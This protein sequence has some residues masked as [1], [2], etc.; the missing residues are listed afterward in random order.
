MIREG[1]AKGGTGE[2]LP[3]V[4]MMAVMTEVMAGETNRL[5]EGGAKTGYHRVALYESG[6]VLFVLDLLRF[7]MLCLSE[8]VGSLRGVFGGVQTDVQDEL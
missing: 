3:D 1:I 2:D 4:E 7:C 8:K 6:G 5:V